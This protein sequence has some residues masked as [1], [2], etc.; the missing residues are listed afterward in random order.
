[1]AII[2]LFV[3]V[4]LLYY[5]RQ[6][7]IKD[8]GVLDPGIRDAGV[9]VEAGKLLL[10]GQN[11]YVILENRFGFVGCIPFA[12]IS[13]LVPSNF[14]TL[15][16]QLLNILGII[17]FIFVFEKLFTKTNLGLV[18]ISSLLLSS[19]REMLVTNQITGIIMGLV[20]LGYYFSEAES[21]SKNRIQLFFAAGLFTI[22]LDLKPHLVMI[23]LGF[24]IIR[25]RSKSLFVSITAAWILLHGIVNLLHQEIL[26]L[27]WFKV[28]TN[29]QY[30]A[31]RGNLADSVSIWPI[32]EEVTGNKDFSI[33]ILMLPIVSGAILL[34][35]NAR[36]TTLSRLLIWPF[37]LPSLSSYFHHYDLIPVTVLILMQVNIKN[38]KYVLMPLMFF[39][40][41]IEN[42]SIKNQVLVISIALLWKWELKS[43]FSYAFIVLSWLGYNLLNLTNL[44]FESLIGNIQAIVVTEIVFMSVLISILLSIKPSH[45]DSR[46][47]TTHAA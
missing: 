11:P 26:E 8:I 39:V 18:V 23:F 20:A 1:M 25:T 2:S 46:T 14:E 37:L 41:P 24:Y 13:H 44:Y 36:S 31:Q 40:I 42:S 12:V 15:I 45:G 19:T 7:G 27:D 10:N 28:I 4:Y 34:F 38:F 17:I 35:L 47:K 29:L 32:I 43:D 21:K 30:Q 3:L 16:F 22:A 6:G 9:Y 5:Y 33:F